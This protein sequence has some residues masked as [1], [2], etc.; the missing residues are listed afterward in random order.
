LEIGDLLEQ[1]LVG[2]LETV[3]DAQL[4]DVA[5]L[6]VAMLRN[7]LAQQLLVLQ[8]TVTLLLKDSQLIAVGVGQ[9]ALESDIVVLQLG[10]FCLGLRQ[11]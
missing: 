6:F 8:G 5:G 9:L 10:E 7:R 2:L 3:E 4:L 11:L 1:V